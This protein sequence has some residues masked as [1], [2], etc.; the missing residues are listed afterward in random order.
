MIAAAD[1]AARNWFA[2]SAPA[3]KL[4][5]LECSSERDAEPGRSMTTLLAF[6]NFRRALG[7]KTRDGNSFPPSQDLSPP[8]RH[9][10]HS[11]QAR[12]FSLKPLGQTGG[13]EATKQQARMG[14]RGVGFSGLVG[15]RGRS[16][17]AE[18]RGGK[19]PA[20]VTTER[21][22]IRHSV[23]PRQFYFACLQGARDLTRSGDRRVATY[24]AP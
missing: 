22:R 18:R 1:A 4:G 16:V 14:C 24:A 11:R 7:K 13:R 20:R 6:L 17:L 5:G 10:L 12:Y 15:H 21:F 23:A 9:R 8:A 19:S 2:G 3:Q